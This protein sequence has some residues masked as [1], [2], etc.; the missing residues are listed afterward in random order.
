MQ[1]STSPAS[2]PGDQPPGPGVAAS[3]AP[4][5]GNPRGW[6]R[7][8]LRCEEGLH[9]PPAPSFLGWLLLLLGQP[10]RLETN[11]YQGHADLHQL[12]MG[13]GP[14]WAEQ[15]R[16]WGR[17]LLQGPQIRVLWIMGLNNQPAFNNI[18]CSQ[19]SC[20]ASQSAIE[21]PCIHA[22]CPSTHCQSCHTIPFICLPSN[23]LFQ[24]PILHQITCSINYSSSINSTTPTI[25]PLRT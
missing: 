3:G 10:G 21:R 6:E 2:L 23:Q 15:G 14:G 11:L 7:H 22:G 12:C 20:L 9:H 5:G 17:C 13:L 25:H 18:P 19:L 1:P 16:I 8:L 4:P 24:S